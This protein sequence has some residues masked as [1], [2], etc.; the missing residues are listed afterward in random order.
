[1]LSER[2]SRNHDAIAFLTTM[3]KVFCLALIRSKNRSASFHRASSFRADE[4]RKI[5]AP[6]RCR[7][8]L[9]WGVTFDHR[10]PCPRPFQALL[11]WPK[12]MWGIVKGLRYDFRPIKRGNEWR[13][14]LGT[15]E[16]AGAARDALE[17]F[18]NKLPSSQLRRL[19]F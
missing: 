18:I 3:L 10:Q 17:S 8:A 2:V 14:S 1:M 11:G 5:Q 16:S 13:H 7:A 9:P 12:S 4:T 15:F 19:L 6:P